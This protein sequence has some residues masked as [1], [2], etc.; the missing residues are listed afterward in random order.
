MKLEKW[1][2]EYVG[3]GDPYHSPEMGSTRALGFIYGD[4]RRFLDG[5]YIHTSSLVAKKGNLIKTHSGSVYELGTPN[6]RFVE[7]LTKRGNSIEDYKDFG[8]IKKEV[9][10]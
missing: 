8:E 5:T 3:D 6:P 4:G 2:F 1:F 9:L 7:W 10:I